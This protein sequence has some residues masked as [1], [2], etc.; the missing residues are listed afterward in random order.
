MSLERLRGEQRSPVDLS[1]MGFDALSWIPLIANIAID[2]L[3]RKVKIDEYV[4]TLQEASDIDE[5]FHDMYVTAL[6]ISFPFGLPLAGCLFHAS[7]QRQHLLRCS[8]GTGLRI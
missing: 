6:T 4:C 5:G 7:R 1:R 8:H 2:Y 3:R